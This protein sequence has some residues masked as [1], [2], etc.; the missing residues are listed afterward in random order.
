MGESR[1][2]VEMEIG[3]KKS[4]VKSRKWEERCENGKGKEQ[5]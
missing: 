2:D 4:W 3:K 1:I 5:E